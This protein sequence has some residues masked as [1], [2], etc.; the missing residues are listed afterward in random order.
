MRI[1]QHIQHV[2]QSH[3]IIS[4]NPISNISII[5]LL[6]ITSIRFGIERWTHIHHI[7]TL[8][9]FEHLQSLM[10]S[11]TVSI[12]PSHIT[13]TY[14]TIISIFKHEKNITSTASGFFPARLRL[15]LPAGKRCRAALEALEKVL[16]NR[17]WRRIL[18]VF[19]RISGFQKR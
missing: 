13:I 1:L 17:P 4:Q 10:V 15:K 12:Y 6:S 2:H 5:S 3:L 16:D 19:R 9:I 8:N 18:G 11:R 14:S 7:P